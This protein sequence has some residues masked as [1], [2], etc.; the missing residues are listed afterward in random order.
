M[1]SSKVIEDW[2]EWTK[3]ESEE[4]MTLAITI[5]LDGV[6]LQVNCMH[7]RE[8]LARDEMI[9][10]HTVR[11]IYSESQVRDYGRAYISKSI[12]YIKHEMD[13]LDRKPKR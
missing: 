8:Y 6:K 13:W 5:T 12:E 1:L 2:L 10:A 7:G 9:S 4:L 3:I 11:S